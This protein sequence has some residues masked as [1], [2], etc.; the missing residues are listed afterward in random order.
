MMSYLI[1]VKRLLRDNDHFK[2]LRGE[3]SHLFSKA[4]STM[5]HMK[6]HS[7][8]ATLSLLSLSV[9]SAPPCVAAPSATDDVG[10][11]SQELTQGQ[12]SPHDEPTPAPLGIRVA[13][14][15]S[16][17]AQGSFL[18]KP[19][20]EYFYVGQLRGDY[21][22]PGF[23]GVGAVAGAQLDLGWRFIT[24]STGYMEGFD[25]AE[26][27]TDGFTVTMTQRTRHI[28]LTLR[29]K[30]PSR[31]ASPSICGGVDWVMPSEGELKTKGPMDFQG[32][33][34][35]AYRAWTF[36]LGVD[37]MLTDVL[38]LPI[39][40]Y[41]ILNPT[42]KDTLNDAL[43]WESAPVGRPSVRGEWDWQAGVTLGVSYDV[44]RR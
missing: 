17:G 44:Y 25:Q 13:L 38:R 22:Y 29:F 3:L 42:P 5:T 23:G 41:G 12:T 39:R 28:P 30:L 16:A 21:V 27:K 40:L 20:D 19:S 8:Y 43:L 6:L 34:S 7:I 4:N 32:V 2:G 36:G 18:Q 10:K 11:D 31:I 33:K 14:G 9:L 1:Y 26:G 37:V 24:L 15:V 35:E